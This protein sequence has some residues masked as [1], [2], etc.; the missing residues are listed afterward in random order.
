MKHKFKV[1]D[2]V[3]FKSWEE[4]KEEFGVTNWGYI[5]GTFF[6]HET[7]LMGKIV[8]IKEIDGNQVVLEEEDYHNYPL[9]VL[10]PFK[11]DLARKVKDLEDCVEYGLNGCKCIIADD[12]DWTIDEQIKWHEEKLAELKAQK[13][14][15]KWVFTEDEK[16]IL[17]NLPEEY[18][19]IARGMDGGLYIFM[20][21]PIKHNIDWGLN[22]MSNFRGIPMFKHIFQCIQWENESPCNFREVLNAE[23]KQNKN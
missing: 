6:N 3:Q 9:D 11:K 15:E 12:F 21:K 8:T 18:K 17:R 22:Y 10:K 4:L 7:E 13:E 1:G 20:Q 5:K 14:K 16:V 23:E 19:W 2:R